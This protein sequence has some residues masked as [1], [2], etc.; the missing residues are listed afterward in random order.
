MILPETYNKFYERCLK[1]MPENLI[2]TDLSDGKT[3]FYSEALELI[4][5]NGISNFLGEDDFVFMMHQGY[6]FWYFKADGN[7]N[8][9]VYGFQDGKTK[10][11]D[12]GSF[13]HFI[14]EFK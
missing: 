7:S 9:I 6:T 3:G 10:P 1:K 2:G 11:D 4:D 12:L 5:E 14:S 8:P 13:S